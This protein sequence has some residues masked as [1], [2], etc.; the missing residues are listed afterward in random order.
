MNIDPKPINQENVK[1]LKEAIEVRNEAEKELVSAVTEAFHNNLD[2]LQQLTHEYGNYLYNLEGDKLI[3]ND[4]PSRIKLLSQYNTA[5]YIDLSNLKFILKGPNQKMVYPK[6]S[7]LT[8]LLSNDNI[9]ELVIKS[10]DP[11]NLYEASIKKNV[12]IASAANLQIKKINF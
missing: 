10:S 8:N 5:L 9:F 6:Q 12:E 3:D 2:K 7:I 1:G 11:N 4:D